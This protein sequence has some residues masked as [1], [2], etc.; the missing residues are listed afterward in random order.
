MSNHAK[1]LFGSEL[2]FP[3]QE[4]NGTF[5]TVSGID[6]LE[7]SIRA[8]VE[9][10]KGEH[11]MHPEYGWP[12]RELM[13][14]GDSDEISKTVRQAIMDGESRIDYSDL[15]V[16]AAPLENDVVEISV[17]Y[18]VKAYDDIRRTIKIAVPVD[19]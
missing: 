17:N 7:Q 2:A 10:E 9:T 14:K 18:S 19:L 15:N 16:K 11:V 8:I 1:Y 6:A 12:I 13:A 3:I 5:K 4:E